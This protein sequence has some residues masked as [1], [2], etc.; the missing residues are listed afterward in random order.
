MLCGYIS[1]TKV[2]RTS[3]RNS[4][5]PRNKLTVKKKLHNRFCRLGSGHLSRL[6]ARQGFEQ[7]F[8]DPAVSCLPFPPRGLGFTRVKDNT[9]IEKWMTNATI[10]LQNFSGDLKNPHWIQS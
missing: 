2:I 8:T 5:F 3:N 6:T 10:N 9:I 4:E 7:G 1:C